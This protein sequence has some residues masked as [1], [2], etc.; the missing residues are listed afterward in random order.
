MVDYYL[1][2][3][4][5]TE[6]EPR[7]TML[8]KGLRSTMSSCKECNIYFIVLNVLF[9]TQLQYYVIKLPYTAGNIFNEYHPL[10]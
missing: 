3:T 5:S 4:L 6:A 1:K 10:L 7:S 8:F 2:K 9:P